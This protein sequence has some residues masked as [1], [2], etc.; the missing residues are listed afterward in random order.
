VGYGGNLYILQLP[1]AALPPLSITNVNGIGDIVVQD[2]LAYI[3]NSSGLQI[4]NVSNP[5]NPSFTGQLAQSIYGNKLTVAEGYAYIAN[6]YD[7]L[8]I[9]DVSDPAIPGEVGMYDVYGGTPDVYISGNYAYLSQYSDGMIILDISDPSDPVFVS[10]FTNADY[11][12]EIYVQ[13][14]YAYVADYY[15]GL[16]IVDV[17]NPLSPFEVGNLNTIQ[18]SRIKT[19]GNFAYVIN[20]TVNNP[21]S[22]VI[23]NISNP[24]VP[25]KVGTIE[26]ANITWD[27]DVS[28]SYV[29]VASYTDGLK[30]YDVSNPSNPTFAGSYT[31]YEVQDVQV[32]GN[33]AY[34]ASPVF[35]GGI[36]ILD[37]T[38]PANPTLI[39]HYNPGP[40]CFDVAVS[41]NYAYLSAPISQADI[42]LLDITN[43]NN[44]IELDD[45]VIPTGASGMQAVGPYLYV[46]DGEAGLQI[47]RNTLIPIPVELISFT[48]SILNNIVRLNW[49]TSTETN[50]DG[51]EIQRKQDNSDWQK[52]G[53]VT[54]HGTAT[55]TNTY[56]YVDDISRLSSN[57]FSYRLKQLDFDGS[58]EYSDEVLVTNV[59]PDKFVLEQNFPNPFNPNTVIKYSITQT[60]MVTLT[61]YNILGKKVTTLV[62]ETKEA[63]RYEVNFN[64]S[65]LA[66]GLYFYNIKS[67]NFSAVKKM[68]LMK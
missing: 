54:G 57:S 38:N 66:S 6:G 61:V 4:W 16:R 27:I 40:L 13:G 49:I 33:T 18:A 36:I 20:G 7:G 50:N 31:T 8:R 62:N 41:G 55:E 25:L 30:I 63:G 59:T 17:S 43:P 34:V 52:I 11:V 64:A 39:S 5:N 23:V 35:N 14:S 42:I 68:V 9:I 47:V 15:G 37:V 45:H 65:N 24:A 2:N 28:G 22:L 58:Y 3:I 10:N 53:F 60:G 48:A 44:P 46:A 21:D 67:G 26:V 29:Y 56:E 12:S 1:N 51:F 19:V 32:I